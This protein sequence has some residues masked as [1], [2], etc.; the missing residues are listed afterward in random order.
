[1][2]M[3][4]EMLHFLQQLN[5]HLYYQN[6]QIQKI[7]AS[8]QELLREFNQFKEK[9]T[10]PPVTR[11]EYR[12]D[13][14]KV[15][16]LEGTLNIGVNPTG[17]DSSIEE[18]AIEQKI[19][20]PSPIEKQYPQLHLD[21]KQQVE[22]YLNKGAYDSLKHME[23]ENNFPLSDQYR[24]FIVDDVKKQI[25]QQIRGYLKQ[26]DLEEVGP[27]PER[28]T[29]IQQSVF[30]NVKRDIEKTFETFI[31]NLHRNEKGS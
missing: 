5:G 28:L 7:D 23:N 11:N 19:D 9:N 26:I 22:E 16:R 18:F 3:S 31:K 8:L 25:D 15:E 20:V 21:I 14:L 6:Q 2:S 30:N 4:P 10:E 13:L 17:S 1:M 24:K 29:N 12:F 27:E